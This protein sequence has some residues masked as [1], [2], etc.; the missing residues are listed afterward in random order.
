MKIGHD[1]ARRDEFVAF[2]PDGLVK[3]HLKDRQKMPELF[4]AIRK[5]LVMQVHQVE[6]VGTK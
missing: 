3:L 1:A 5:A 6:I 2:D 4:A